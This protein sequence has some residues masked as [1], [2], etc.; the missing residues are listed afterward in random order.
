[1]DLSEHNPT[2]RFS[3]RADFYQRYRPTYPRAAIDLIMGRGGLGASSLLVDV[4]AGTG[5]S[6]RLFAARGVPV[7]GI[8][9]NAEMR[10]RAENTPVPAGQQSPQFRDGTGEATGLPDGAATVVLSAQAF[11]WCQADVALQEF[12]RILQPGGW[13]ALMWNERDE[14][15]AL[16]AAYGDLLRALPDTAAI[17]GSRYSAGEPLLTSP[18]FEEAARHVFP[19]QQELDEEGMLGRAFS[20][21]YVPQQGERA[22]QLARDLREL[23]GRFQRRGQVALRYETSVYLARKRASADLLPSPPYSGERGWG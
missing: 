20:S 3:D 16:T 6:A 5:I 23:F 17:E 11:H 7:V 2:Q 19:S 14:T 1:M 12:A 15:D 18:L 8:E 13:V 10:R 4:G 21:S 9:P 22:D